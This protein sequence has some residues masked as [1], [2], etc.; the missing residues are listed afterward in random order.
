MKPGPARRGARAARAAST[1]LSLP[2]LKHG[3]APAVTGA[4]EIKED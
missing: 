3:S 2:A 1:R 4:A